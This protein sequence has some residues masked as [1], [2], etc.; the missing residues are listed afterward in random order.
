MEPSIRVGAFVALF[1]EAA[2]LLP[3]PR[4]AAPRGHESST[5]ASNI[6]RRKVGPEEA[7]EGFLLVEKAW[8]P[9]LPAPGAPFHLSVGN[10][11]IKTKIVESPPCT[12]RT[13]EHVHYR[14]GLPLM[15]P[16]EGRTATLRVVKGD[17][18]V[19]EYD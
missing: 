16:T 1:V 12:C 5:M 7:E 10:S 4:F 19:L 3:R 9:K 18:V 14:I 8:L 15:N 6:M 13:P 17:K 11:T 2:P